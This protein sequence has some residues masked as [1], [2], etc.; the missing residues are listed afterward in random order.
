VNHVAR[1]LKSFEWKVDDAF[2]KIKSCEEWRKEH[3]CLE[4]KESEI[5]QELNMKV[6]LELLFL[7]IFSVALCKVMIR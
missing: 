6:S 7:C 5:D 2:D 3:G 4:V 1:Y